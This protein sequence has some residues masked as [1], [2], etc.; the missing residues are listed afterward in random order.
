MLCEFVSTHRCTQGGGFVSTS[1]DGK[2]N[3]WSLAN[4]IDPAESIQIGDSISSFDVAAETGGTLVFGDDH[5]NLHAAVPSGQRRRQV[6]KLAPADG[7]HYG[8]V[9]SLSSKLLLGKAHNTS[10][11]LSKGFLRG[12]A[13]LIL[14][15][16]VDWTV[17]LWAPA[18]QDTPLTSFVSHSYDSMSDVQ[19]SPVNPSL[20]ATCSSNGTA[21]LWNLATSLEE[22]IESI[23]VD[24]EKGLN[25]LMWS[26]DGR[27]L[28]VAS[29]D[30]LHILTFTEEMNARAEEEGKIMMNKFVAREWISNARS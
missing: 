4:L 18:L 12:S 22:P 25:K 29:Y 17:K 27:R 21:S 23:A 16:G 3:F 28:A 8:M 10:E 6:R 14:S 7:G 1:S 9:T 13:G 2:V 5:G 19:W 24:E 30:K 20:F 11:G 26:L 15:A